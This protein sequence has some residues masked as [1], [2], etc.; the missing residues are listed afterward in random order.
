MENEKWNGF[1]GIKNHNKAVE[2]KCDS[3]TLNEQ[4]E[5]LRKALLIQNIEVHPTILEKII[6]TYKLVKQKG[7]DISLKDISKLENE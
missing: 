2:I 4:K 5:Y 3:K 1:M 6:K 7:G